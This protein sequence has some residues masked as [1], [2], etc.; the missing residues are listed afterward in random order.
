[1]LDKTLDRF[2]GVFFF[3][4]VIVYVFSEGT[5]SVVAGYLAL[6]WVLIFAVILIKKKLNGL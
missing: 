4:F 3:A 6:A 1:M 5:A 2:F